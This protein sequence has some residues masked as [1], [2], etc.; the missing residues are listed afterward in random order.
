MAFKPKTKEELKKATPRELMVYA[1]E[2]V[3]ELREDDVSPEV[4]TRIQ[5]LLKKFKQLLDKKN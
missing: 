1:Y 2:S 3:S 4:W 5:T